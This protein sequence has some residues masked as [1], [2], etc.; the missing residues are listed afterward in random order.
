MAKLDLWI[1]YHTSVYF[2][3]ILGS[4]AGTITTQGSCAL[5]I[6]AKN[7]NQSCLSWN[8]NCYCGSDIFISYSNCGYYY[9]YFGTCPP[10]SRDPCSLQTDCREPYEWPHP[11]SLLL[12]NCSMRQMCDLTAP[13]KVESGEQTKVYNCSVSYQCGS[14]KCKKL[15]CACK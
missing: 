10:T 11:Q 15:H 7:P 1:V 9:R 13:F 14:G 12:Q 2:F 4:T 5:N 8:F 6:A 3:F